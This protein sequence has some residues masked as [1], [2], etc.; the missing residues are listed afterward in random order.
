MIAMP[1]ITRVNEIRTDYVDRVQDRIYLATCTLI[2]ESYIL[3]EVFSPII[4]EPETVHM[5]KIDLNTAQNYKDLLVGL[6]Y[7]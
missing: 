1:H 5:D 6:G 3:L 7:Y 4:Y 2:S